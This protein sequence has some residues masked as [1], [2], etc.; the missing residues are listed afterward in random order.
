MYFPLELRVGCWISFPGL[1]S[2]REK[3]LQIMCVCVCSFVYGFLPFCKW[4]EILI[5]NLCSS[6]NK[7]SS[8][9]HN[10]QG[11]EAQRGQQGDDEGCAFPE[12]AG[13]QFVCEFIFP[14]KNE[15]NNSPRIHTNTWFVICEMGMSF[16]RETLRKNI[17]QTFGSWWI[18]LL[19]LLLRYCTDCGT[20]G[21]RRLIPFFTNI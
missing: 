2:A 17:S 8:G 19:P 15:H 9:L 11:N 12:S 20:E 10:S 13:H 3:H 4:E 5:P 1:S 18:E 7:K 16:C 14:L 6:D 21:L